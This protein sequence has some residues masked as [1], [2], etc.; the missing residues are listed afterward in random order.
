MKRISLLL[1]IVCLAGGTV[2]AQKTID[3]VAAVVGDKIIL[4][5][6][7]E[8]Q[9][10]QMAA[11]GYSGAEPAL[12]CQLLEEQLYQKL[13]AHQAEVDSIVVT[14]MEINDAIDQRIRYFVS[15]IGS[16]EK[17][18]EYFGKSIN[19]IKE[20]FKPV[21][22]DQLLAQRMEG[23]VTSDVTV[24][25][26]GVRK[27]YNE[28]PKDSLPI[29]PL[30]LEVSQLLVIPEV[31]VKEEERLE[32][33]LNSFKERVKNG[34]DFSILA[35][36]YSEDKGSAKNSGE[37]GFL[38]RGVLVPEF[39]AVAFR[40]QPGELSEIVQTKFGFHLIQMIARRGEQVN[41]RHILLKPNVSAESMREAKNKL[42]SVMQLV[43]MDSLSFEEAA[44]KF[45][46]DDT[47][48]N[49]GLILNPQ[50][51][52]ASFTAEELD[53]SIFFLVEKMEEGGCSPATPFTTI[54]ERKAYRVIRLN[55]KS[56]S[57]RANLK[58]D[59]DRIQTVAL[60]ELK[61]KATKEWISDK[62]SKTYIKIQANYACDW[63]NNWRK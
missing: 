39:E 22:K 24:T 59:Y 46:D 40:L 42:D 6:A 4:H 15:Q 47:K 56:D 1:V 43:Q 7:I 38:A 9:Y 31:D 61:A 23:K 5:S 12:K 16:E 48:N 17:L 11:Q 44:L 21:F 37:L 28:I 36:L 26:E 49:G 19:Q 34:E 50:T 8:G 25:P 57:H 54:D 18:A 52:T 30:E 27:F 29:L 41:V 51:G 58:D 33:K 45:S 20:E 2:N 32:E 10:Q 55:K 60:Q 63:K 62:I 14:E 35:T 53:P 3:G 13:L